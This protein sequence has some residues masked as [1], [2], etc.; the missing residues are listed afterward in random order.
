MVVIAP[1][2]DMP[3]V[4]TDGKGDCQGDDG[5]QC[6]IHTMVLWL[7]DELWRDGQLLGG[8]GS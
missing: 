4:A 5:E 1:E 7:L 6:Q 8:R 3:A 2:P